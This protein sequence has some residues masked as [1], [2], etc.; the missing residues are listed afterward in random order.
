MAVLETPLPRIAA[1]P[2]GRSVNPWVVT[3]SVMLATFMEILDTTVVN[4][5]IPHISGNL[6]A[7][8][9]EGTWV[10]TSYLVANAIILP[11]SGWLANYFGR[12]RM[13]LACVIGFTSSSVL[14]GMSR[15]LTGLIIFRILQGLSGGGMQPLAQSIMLEAFPRE[16][17]GHAMAAYGV[18]VVLAPILGPTLGGWVTDNYSWRWIFYLNVPIGLLS[19]FL[20]SRFVFDPAYIKRPTGRVDLWGIGFLALGIGL[21]QVILDTGQRKD[22]YSSNQ[23]RVWTVACV[24]GLVLFLWRELTVRDP[25]VDLRVLRDTTYSAGVLL[26]TLLGFVLYASLVLLPIYLQTLLG[27]PAFEAGLAISPRGLGALIM[28]PVAGI[29]THK[30]GP[31]R[32]VVVGLVLGGYTMWQFSALNLNAGYWD[33]FWPSVIQGCGMSF[34]FIPIMAAAMSRIDKRKMGNAT[35]IFNLMRNIGGSFGIA[36]MTTFLTRRQQ[37]HHNHLISNISPY[38]PE[39][40]QM[41]QAAKQWFMFRGADAHTAMLRAYGAIYATVQRHAAMLAFVEAFRVMAVVFFLMIALVL[42]LRPVPLRE[43]NGPAPH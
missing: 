19:V 37:V 13:L 10:V 22:W 7:S 11:L 21:L 23:I 4:V 32:L 30:V 41:L 28:T 43:H 39:T 33:V 27:Y 24:A 12:R 20:V 14:C 36:L 31:R 35:S 40:W 3:L 1:P 8:V 34:L 38:D 17:H 16:K 9:E 15:T 6:S 42:V 25:V 2:A 5:S 29:L 18:G 26:I